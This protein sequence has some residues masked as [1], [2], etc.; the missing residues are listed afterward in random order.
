[1]C[2][3]VLTRKGKIVSCNQAT[4]INI[5]VHNFSTRMARYLQNATINVEYDIL[6]L[7]TSIYAQLPVYRGCNVLLI[8]LSKIFFGLKTLPLE[9]RLH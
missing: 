3:S 7:S 9:L 1:M 8:D 2:S 4:N 5:F 6:L